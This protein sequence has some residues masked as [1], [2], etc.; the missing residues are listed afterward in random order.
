MSHE[1]Y[2]YKVGDTVTRN[3]CGML[4]DLKVTEVTEDKI[5]CGDWEFCKETGVEIDDTIDCVV[6]YLLPK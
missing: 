1:M 2:N 4:M 5:I 3:M 6:S